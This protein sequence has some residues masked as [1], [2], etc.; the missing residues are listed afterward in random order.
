MT[1]IRAN[2]PQCG[3]VELPSTSIVLEIAPDGDQ[4]AYT[5]VCPACEQSVEKPADRRIVLLLRSAGV[6]LAEEEGIDVGE[7]HGSPLT[8]DDLIDFHFLLRR[9]DW[10]TELV[11]TAE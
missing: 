4:G 2:C 10:F 6:T 11:A 1:T 5:F 9:D 7:S 3:E 8:L